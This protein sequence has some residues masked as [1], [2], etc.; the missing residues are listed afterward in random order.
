M[1]RVPIARRS[2]PASSSQANERENRLMGDDSRHGVSKSV[3]MED[4]R[5]IRVIQIDVPKEK[6]Y[7]R[8]DE[9]DK[10]LLEFLGISL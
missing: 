7:R 4:V 6:K 3:N 2:V 9:K 5:K 10:T 8:T 1:P